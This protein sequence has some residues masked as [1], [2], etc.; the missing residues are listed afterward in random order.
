MKILK[1][2]LDDN[3]MVF[4]VSILDESYETHKI[5]FN[6]FGIAYAD[7]ENRIIVIDGEA[8]LKDRLTPDH[9]L[10]IEAHEIGHY[11]LDHKGVINK[12]LAEIEKEADFAAFKILKEF[13]KNR[14][15]RLLS[16]RFEG[17]YDLS[18]EDYVI[19]PSQRLKIE[20]YI[21]DIKVI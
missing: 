10:A 5:L 2:Q 19:K 9:M 4:T 11:V 15:A 20:N 21:H 12:S 13:D 1:S 18:I 3:W 8:V 16:E 6:N 7:L 17:T 14:A